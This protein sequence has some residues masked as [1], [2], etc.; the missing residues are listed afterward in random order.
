MFD[1]LT[2]WF[3]AAQGTELKLDLE[4]FRAEFWN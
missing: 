1:L 4:E 3:G 2:R